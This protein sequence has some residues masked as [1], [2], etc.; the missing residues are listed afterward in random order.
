MGLE[1]EYLKFI[2]KHTRHIHGKNLLELGN[3]RISPNN[4]VQ[5]ATGKSYFQSLGYNHISVDLNG[6]D[7]A[8]RRDLRNPN[9]FVEFKNYFN[10]ITN[11]GTTEHV[12][13]FDKQYICFKILHEIL[14]LDGIIIH[15]VPTLGSRWHNHCKFYYTEN[16]FKLLATENNYVILEIFYYDEL[17]LVAMQK[18][19]DREFM[20]HIEGFDTMIT[21]ID[22]KKDILAQAVYPNTMVT[23]GR[24][25]DLEK[26]LKRIVTE[27]ISGD[28]VECGTYRGGLAALML[29]YLT[30][31]NLAKTL[32]IYDTFQG[33]SEPTEIDVSIKNEIAID[34]FLSKKNDETNCAEWCKATIDVV[35]STLN[36]VTNEYQKYTK[37]IVGKVED[38][39]LYEAHLPTEISILR[40]DTDWYESTKIE[41]E[42]LYH[43]VVSGGVIIVDDYDYWNGQ[44]QAVDEFFSKINSATFRT[45]NGDDGSLI[46]YKV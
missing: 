31:N 5:Y 8:L 34:E 32:Y 45:E 11:S 20:K 24:V 27:N 28:F 42:K 35:E 9:D 14:S 39:M 7:G 19:E 38:T 13:P 2:N 17:M 40:L 3:Q 37:F 46:I 25:L 36:I 16:F 4:E 10:I 43:R 18:K 15:I 41:L 1:L 33:M 21:R 23:K 22:N 26:E 6:L 29:E 30:D 44:K 12:Q